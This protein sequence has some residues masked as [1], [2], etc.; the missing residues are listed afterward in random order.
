MYS[1]YV[2]K[3]N[4]IFVSQLFAENKGFLIPAGCNDDV[5]KWKHFPRYWS[6]LWGIHWSPVDS[7]HKGQWRWALMFSLISAWI[8]GWV[9]NREASDLRRHRAHYNVTVMYDLCSLLSGMCI[10]MD[11]SIT[12]CV[13]QFGTPEIASITVQYVTVLRRAKHNS[14]I[15]LL[16]GPHI[17]RENLVNTMAVDAM[18]P[19]FVR[20]SAVTLLN[21]PDKP[22]L[23]FH[24]EG[25]HLPVTSQ[26]SGM[27]ESAILY[28]CFVKWIKHD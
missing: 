4:V 23:V 12:P 16:L 2:I 14:W 17:P 28:L 22:A 18:A 5:I 8:N 25:S 11:L 6:F 9:N 24:R 15:I 19:C 21:V 3:S 10:M 1:P 26:Y 27:I 20:P 13:T 7:P